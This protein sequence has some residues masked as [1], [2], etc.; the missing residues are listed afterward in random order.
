MLK[1]IQIGTARGHP[2]RCL[3][4][5]GSR[6]TH[7]TKPKS[8]RV[9]N[10][11]NVLNVP[12]G[13]SDQEI[14]RAF[15]D[16]SKKYHP[17]VNRDTRDS[18]VFVKICE[19]YQTLHRH[20]SRQLYD[21]R[22]RMQNHSAVPPDTAFT[23]RHV[24]TVWSQYQSAMRNKQLGRNVVKPF[25]FKTKVQRGKWL[26]MRVRTAE[27]PSGSGEEKA[28]GEGKDQGTKW[29]YFNNNYTNNPTLCV[30][31]TGLCAVSGLVLLD[32]ISRFRDKSSPVDTSN[33]SG[34]L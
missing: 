27:D 32:A 7:L 10:Y 25:I 4:S 8:Q 15:I 28:K 17:D 16:L 2:V 23:G 20:Q 3:A 30:Y 12:V 6:F 26:P 18:E 9:E 21:S 29:Q 34:S 13:S 24:S 33:A 19:A 31:I 14:K 1:T 11:Y 5:Y 22:L